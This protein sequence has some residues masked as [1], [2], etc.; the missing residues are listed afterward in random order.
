MVASWRYPGGDAGRWLVRPSR[1][2]FSGAGS[3]L[4]PARR[5]WAPCPGWP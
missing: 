4:W 1:S 3:S 5:S 2:A